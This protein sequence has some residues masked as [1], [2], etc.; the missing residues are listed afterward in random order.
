MSKYTV[1]VG[2]NPETDTY[3]GEILIS[4]SDNNINI[5]ES[6][7]INV[8]NNI[9]KLHS[10]SNTGFIFFIVSIIA[11]IGTLL[12]N[13]FKNGINIS[14][15]EKIIILITKIVFLLLTITTIVINIIT[16]IPKTLYKKYYFAS[17]TN[18]SLDVIENV[19]K[20]KM[21]IKN[22]VFLILSILFGLFIFYDLIH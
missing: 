16:L 22:V 20:S 2:Y 8:T 17:G 14:N 1:A 18:D 21:D 3:E 5:K 10:L 15:K 12:I 7:I 4:L 9:L 13:K 19:Y 6:K 11:I